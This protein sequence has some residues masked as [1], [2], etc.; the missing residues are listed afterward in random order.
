[1]GVDE[2]YFHV[3]EILRNAKFVKIGVLHEAPAN[4]LGFDYRSA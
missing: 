4:G 2:G 3:G 1:M